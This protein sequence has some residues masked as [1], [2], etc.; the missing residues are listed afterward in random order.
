MRDI[1]RDFGRRRFQ[2]IFQFHDILR[3]NS[4]ATSIVLNRFEFNFPGYES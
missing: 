1:G 4:Y 2:T 3:C